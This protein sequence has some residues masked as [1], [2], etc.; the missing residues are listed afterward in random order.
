[1]EAVACG[2][3]VVASPSGGSAEGVRD[4]ETGSI[5]PPGD[6]TALADALARLLGDAP[7]RL[8]LGT[9]ARAFAEEAFS[10]ARQTE[11]LERIYDDVV[12]GFAALRSG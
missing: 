5:V 8:Q 4:G 9:A 7:L 6:E 11:R 1:M 2:L 10:L 12:A 3:P